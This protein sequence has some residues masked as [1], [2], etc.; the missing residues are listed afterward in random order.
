MGRT[1][2]KIQVEN[3][4]DVIRARAGEI[5]EGQVRRLEID[6]LVDTGATL[7]CLPKSKIDL[8]GLIFFE[9][10]RAT[11]ANGPV[12]RGI[13][14]SA[15][16]TVLERS[17]SIDVMELPEDAPPLV[18]YLALEG[19]DFVVDPRSQSVIPNPAHEGKFVMD[20]Y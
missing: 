6:A 19:L 14:K 10:R 13:Y 4:A 7:L 9:T 15:H 12:D 18:G 11:T 8:L 17:C 16:L 1:T 5:P 3:L 2:V 20:L